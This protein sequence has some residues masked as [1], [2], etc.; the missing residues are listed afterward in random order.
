MFSHQI[1]DSHELNNVLKEIVK[2]H[3]PDPACEMGV[4]H[5]RFRSS[6]ICVLRKFS[7]P[8]SVLLGVL[9]GSTPGLLLFNIFNHSN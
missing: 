6:F 4:A 7:S 8:L 3:G 1:D 2:L 9:Q 5:A